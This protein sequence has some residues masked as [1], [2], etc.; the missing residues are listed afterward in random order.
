[1]VWGQI[2]DTEIGIRDR[3][4]ELGWQISRRHPGWSSRQS[5]FH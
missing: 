3:L 5:V 2:W 1:M 4:N